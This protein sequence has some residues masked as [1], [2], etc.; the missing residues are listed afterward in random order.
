MYKK[1]SE[2]FSFDYSFR[3]QRPHPLPPP[4]KK[5]E[6]TVTKLEAVFLDPHRIMAPLLSVIQILI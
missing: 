1:K 5:Y 6:K 2:I 4:S 3:F